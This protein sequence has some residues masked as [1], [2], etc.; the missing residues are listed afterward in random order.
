[1]ARQGPHTAGASGRSGSKGNHP[2]LNRNSISQARHA[3]A[4]GG[5]CTL[6]EPLHFPMGGFGL[7][8]D[9]LGALQLLVCLLPQ[10]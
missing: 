10:I 7:L 5:E 2:G 8:T 4:P 9:I 6:E 3:A 1:M